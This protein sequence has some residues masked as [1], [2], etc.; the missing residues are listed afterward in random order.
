MWVRHKRKTKKYEKYV[1]CFCILSLHSLKLKNRSL[2]YFWIHFQ[3]RQRRRPQRWWSSFFLRA[4]TTITITI[5]CMILQIYCKEITLSC[6]LPTLS[7]LCSLSDL[8]RRWVRVTHDA[9]HSSLYVCECKHGSNVCA[10]N[11]YY[12]SFA[13]FLLPLMRQSYS[14][15]YQ[16]YL[17][18]LR[19]VKWLKDANVNVMGANKTK[20]VAFEG[21]SNEILMHNNSHAG[22]TQ[23]K[24]N[25][26]KWNPIDVGMRWACV[27]CIITIKLSIKYRNNLRLA[28][29]S[30]IW[31]SRNFRDISIN[32]YCFNFN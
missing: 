7:S 22:L 28:H 4:V 3:R 25:I 32:N 26:L 5:M 2:I 10:T 16:N 11:C 24:V 31:Q 18:S 1:A 14:E 19:K 20:P 12:V 27:W 8:C 9:I 23:Q 6:V 30:K 13:V 17:K 15:H 29:H 21:W